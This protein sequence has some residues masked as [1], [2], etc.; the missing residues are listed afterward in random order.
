MQYRNYKTIIKDRREYNNRIREI[1]DV[2]KEEN[3]GQPVACGLDAEPESSIS[4]D[5]TEDSGEE[6]NK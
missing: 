4:V 3:G 5:Q 2:S 1:S 6:I